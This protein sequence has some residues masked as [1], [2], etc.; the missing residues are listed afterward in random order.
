MC[1]CIGLA[2]DVMSKCHVLAIVVTDVMFWRSDSCQFQTFCYDLA[3]PAYIIWCNKQVKISS[4]N[5]S[6]NQSLINSQQLE[7]YSLAYN[8]IT[9][10]TFFSCSLY[11]KIS[12]VS[13]HHWSWNSRSIKLESIYR[14]PT[15]LEIHKLQ[16]GP[17]VACGLEPLPA[18][19]SMV[20]ICTRHKSRV[21]W[22]IYLH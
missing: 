8:N 11:T 12:F 21:D 22:Y 17:W 3:S 2:M 4:N 14:T 5:K 20:I 10:L 15:R 9:N 16:Q 18:A 19:A 6:L 7:L 13:W 1:N